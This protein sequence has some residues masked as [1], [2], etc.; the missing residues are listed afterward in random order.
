ELTLSAIERRAKMSR[1][2]LTHYF[3]AKEDILLAVFD[4]MIE[5]MR[6][7][8]QAG[9]VWDG[10]KLPPPGWERFRTFLGLF[11]LHPP[12]VPEFHP[13]QYT[14]LSQISHRD[15]FRRRLADLYEKWRAGMAADVQ[16]ELV[17]AGKAHV[18]ARTFASLIQALLHGL[19]VQREADPAA[20]DPA[21]VLDLC[22]ELLGGFL[23]HRDPPP[24]SKKAAPRAKKRKT[25]PEVGE[26]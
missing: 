5:M 25:E 2:Q 15:D 19:A 20:F 7:Q 12:H 3:K 24:A 23:G 16:G 26:P 10:Y 17:A 4:R 13:L 14:F 9:E 8:D 1:G 11:L 22:H 21:D 18:S 6:R